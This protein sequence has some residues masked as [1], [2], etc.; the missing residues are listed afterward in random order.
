MA[1]RWPF[2][3]GPGAC[4]GRGWSLAQLGLERKNQAWAARHWPARSDD[5]PGVRPGPGRARRRPR[6]AYRPRPARPPARGPRPAVTCCRR[7]SVHSRGRPRPAAPPGRAPLLRWDP[8]S[9]GRRP[10][11]GRAVRSLGAGRGER[12]DNAA[13]AEPRCAS[14]TRRRARGRVCICAPVG[15][16]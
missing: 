9:G 12:T 14:G 8:G 6:L 3:T 1:Q 5:D 16:R 4:A 13:R 15:Q 10:S 2:P 11:P 7:C